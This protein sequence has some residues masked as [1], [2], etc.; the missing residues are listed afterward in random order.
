MEGSK[1][2]P[3]PGRD[4]SRLGLI[5]DEYRREESRSLTVVCSV[6]RCSELV[7]RIERYHTTVVWEW[8][9]KKGWD[10]GALDNG[11]HFHLFCAAGHQIKMWGQQ[12]PKRLER[13]VYPP[14]F[15]EEGEER[16]DDA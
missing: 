7:V 1:H 2:Y 16:S 11:T 15:A 14:A 8:D 5:V 9:E 12:L 3:A 4:S 10:L 6:P 13:V